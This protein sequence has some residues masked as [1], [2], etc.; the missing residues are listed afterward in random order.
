[1][2]Q[3]TFACFIQIVNTTR[4][5]SPTIMNPLSSKFWLILNKL[6]QG[7]NCKWATHICNSPDRG[8]DERDVCYESVE[9]R[10]RES[11]G[12]SE[13]NITSQPSQPT[14]TERNRRNPP[15]PPP[16]P[17]ALSHRPRPQPPITIL[18]YALV[19]NQIRLAN[20]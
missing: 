1:M 4:P 20:R 7:V 9:Q 16:P 3:E 12:R 13:R 15:P 10:F 8:R 17:P 5:N 19:I 11:A 14:E 2:T 6:L 18:K